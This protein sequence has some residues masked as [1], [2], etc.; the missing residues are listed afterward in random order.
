MTYRKAQTDRRMITNRWHDIQESP[1]GQEDD[2]KQMTDRKAQTGRRMTT[3]RWH[4]R[5]ES[6]D[7]Q[8][9]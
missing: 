1:D 4:D 7:R 9:E 2:N 5:Q 8:E 6:P 3:N